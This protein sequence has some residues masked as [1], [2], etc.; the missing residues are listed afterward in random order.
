MQV[1]QTCTVC[2][3]GILQAV[4]CTLH[5]G[6]AVKMTAKPIAV[7]E[8]KRLCVLLFTS[9]LHAP[10]RQRYALDDVTPL[11]FCPLHLEAALYRVLQGNPGMQ[12][13]P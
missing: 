2:V 1:Q 7:L 3:C 9:V 5:G 8:K 10:C 11:F 12:G 4:N 13:M 6:T